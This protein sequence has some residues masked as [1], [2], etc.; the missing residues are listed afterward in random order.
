VINRATPFKAHRRRESYKKGK[1]WYPERF[2]QETPSHRRQEKKEE[3][4]RE[5]EKSRVVTGGESGEEG[6]S[7]QE[8]RYVQ[9]KNDQNK[10]RVLNETMLQNAYGSG[11]RAEDGVLHANI[12]PQTT[13]N[14]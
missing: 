6:G 10:N 9:K 7:E 8:L 11:R 12:V 4:K 14:V 13:V 2:V 5:K 3:R 1:R